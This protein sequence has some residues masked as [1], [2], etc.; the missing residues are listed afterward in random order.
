M[1]KLR[2]GNL[3]LVEIPENNITG[4]A[5]QAEIMLYEDR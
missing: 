2:N 4:R 3:N 5:T 1:I